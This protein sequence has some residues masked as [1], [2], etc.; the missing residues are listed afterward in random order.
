MLNMRKLIISIIILTLPYYVVAKSEKNMSE[1]QVATFAGGCF[2]CMQPPFDKTVGVIMTTVGYAGGAEE[3]PSYEQVS[4]GTTGHVEAI[5]IA[6]DPHK[7]SYDKL[8]E[9][10]WHNIDPF[11]GKGQF[12]DKGKQ[13]HSIIFYHDES[14]K[15]S[16]ET[17]K[18]AIE[19]AKGA[20]VVTE[21][22]AYTT[23]YSAEEYH[24]SFYKKSPVRYKFYRYSCGRDK[25]LESLWG[26]TQ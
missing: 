26:K 8:L 20:S 12:C 15:K 9:I 7:V 14:Q 5:Q 1:H 17:S 16:A 2:W 25:R 24:Q 22:I 4:S 21:I 23:F 6:Y 11:D 3:S 19:K 13:Y 18:Q 10:F